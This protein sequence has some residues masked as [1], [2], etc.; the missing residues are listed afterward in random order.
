MQEG[1]NIIK[2]TR[3]HIVDQ[4]LGE[5]SIIHFMAKIIGDLEQ[6]SE[7]LSNLDAQ[8]SQ[9]IKQIRIIQFANKKKE[10]R[11]SLLGQL[12]SRMGSLQ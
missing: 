8:L 3:T 5:V 12:F 6:D 4:H 7:S 2:I 9:L 1:L 10:P 11:R